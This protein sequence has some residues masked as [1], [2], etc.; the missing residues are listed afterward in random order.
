MAVS[1][2]SGNM[3]KEGRCLL[4][5]SKNQREQHLLVVPSEA[6][7]FKCRSPNPSTVG[8]VT[9]TIASTP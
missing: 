9:S 3:A 8:Y 2:L 5:Y 7:P 6:R 4:S 1:V